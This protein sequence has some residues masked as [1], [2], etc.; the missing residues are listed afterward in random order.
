ML[1]HD[2]RYNARNHSSIFCEHK[3]ATKTF[4]NSIVTYL[5]TLIE[6]SKSGKWFLHSII[7]KCM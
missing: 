1:D 3:P 2:F 5:Y 7:L 4:Q 6:Q